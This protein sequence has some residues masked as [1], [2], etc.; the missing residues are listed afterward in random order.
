[1]K[2]RYFY[3]VLIVLMFM[4]VFIST[5]CRYSQNLD[6]QQAAAVVD[7]VMIKGVV[8]PGSN[9][10]SL[11]NEQKQLARQ[12]T[13]KID[14]NTIDS[15][16]AYAAGRLFN[17]AEKYELAITALQRFDSAN[18][19][20]K[21]L[22]LLFELL[23]DNGKV[24]EGQSLFIN[25]IKPKN[26]PAQGKYYDYIMYGYQ[27]QGNNTEALAVIEEAL[28]VLDQSTSRPFIID[29]AEIL[30]NT[31]Q[32]AAAREMLIE[33]QDQ[34][35]NDPGLLNRIT[36]K[37]TLFELVGKP[38]PEILASTWIG[39]EPVQIKDLSGKV[40]MVDFWAPW[41]GPCRSTF[42]HL[43]KLYAEYHN[44]GLEIIGVTRFYGRF[45]QLEQNLQNIT[46]ED[47]LP[48]L[49]KFKQ[50]H[51][52]PFPY[53]IASV[54]DGKN[55]GAV[56]GVLSIPHIVLVDKTGVVRMYALGSGKASEEKLEKG[57]IQ[58]LE[59]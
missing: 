42:P 36:T 13:E 48:W 14:A 56:W 8:L 16:D 51:E 45:N 34:T 11:L 44:K 19:E 22:D 3:Y 57:V 35:Q 58:L 7:S 50:H 32:Q 53:A 12:Y 41:C 20:L 15:K 1:M 37:L 23:I 2:I 10:N 27:E 5:G 30:F 18:V 54:E 21:H 28:T 52:I 43:K 26:P 17:F 39:S 31:G 33:L 55:N 49:E 29:K 38:A 24:E 40:V 46:P 25:N 6:I 4:L 59:E 9:R 47:E